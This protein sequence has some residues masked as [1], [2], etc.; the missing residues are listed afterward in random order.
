MPGESDTVASTGERTN[1]HVGIP[2]ERVVQRLI[3]L[4]TMPP[5]EFGRDLGAAY[6]Q[7]HLSPSRT[8]VCAPSVVRDIKW[9]EW[10]NAIRQEQAIFNLT[11][12]LIPG[13]P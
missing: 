7:N 6:L 9:P 8:V 2:A 11:H 4:F 5:T 13:R 3:D 12:G 1:D 10:D